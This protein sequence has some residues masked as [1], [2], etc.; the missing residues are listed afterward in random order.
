MS[1][2]LLRLL[3]LPHNSVAV[4]TDALEVAGNA[5]VCLTHRRQDFLAA[6]CINWKW[7]SSDLLEK[8]DVILSDLLKIQMALYNPQRILSLDRFS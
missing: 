5:G 6:R 1:S 4:L 7:N 2:V 8:D 3:V